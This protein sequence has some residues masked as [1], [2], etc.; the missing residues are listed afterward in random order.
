[1]CHNLYRE[2]EIG[3]QFVV[4]IPQKMQLNHLFIIADR[5]SFTNN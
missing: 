3:N 5:R 2:D 1:M 4:F